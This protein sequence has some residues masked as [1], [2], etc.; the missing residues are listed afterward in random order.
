VRDPDVAIVGGGLYGLVVAAC[1]ARDLPGIDILVVEAHQRLGG[2]CTSVWH[3]RLGVHVH[4]HGTHI[5]ATDDPRV[6]AFAQAHTRIHRH[7]QRVYASYQGR[8]IPLPLGLEAVEAVFSSG[9]ILTRSHARRLVDQDRAPYQNP[10]PKTVEDAALAQLGPR[11]YEA[12]VRGHV[13]KQWGDPALLTPEVYTSRF[14][15]AYR[16]ARYRQHTRYQGLPAGGWGSMLHRLADRRGIRVQLGRPAGADEPPPYRHALVVTAPLDRWFG[17]DLGALERRSLAVDWRTVRTDR[18]PA[19]ATVTYPDLSVPY[20]RTHTP[21]LL[22]FGTPAVPGKH[23]LVGYERSGTGEY[24]VDFVLR[25][26]GNTDLA[27]AYRTRASALASRHQFFGGRGTTFYDDMGTTIA[28]AMA[29]ADRL[30]Y[31]LRTTSTP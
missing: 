18:A 7:R 28:A 14:G 13:T 10:Q 4:P 31:L 22:P 1:L 19:E 24:Q 30:A 25:T 6:W 27:S 8:L 17:A 9:E 15:I 3:E 20:Y 5:L 16:R 26:P 21:A 2:L 12:F 29:C 11:L 23:S